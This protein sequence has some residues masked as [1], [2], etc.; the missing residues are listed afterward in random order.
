MSRAANN[1]KD[2]KMAPVYLLV[3]ATHLVTSTLVCLV[4]VLGTHDRPKED[5]KKNVPGY[6][7]F[8]AIGTFYL[9]RYCM[10]HV[11]LDLATCLWIDMFFR[12]TTSM[13]RK[14]KVN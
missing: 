13:T 4:E 9:L 5:I 8:F 3:L 14:I 12:V 6:V 2:D 1:T 11:D 7:G 10:T